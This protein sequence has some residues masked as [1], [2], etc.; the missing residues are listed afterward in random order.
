MREQANLNVGIL[1]IF[2]FEI[3]PK[4]YF[5]QVF[6]NY[7]F[8]EE[9]AEYQKEG[10]DVSK[11]EFVDNIECLNMIEK[12]PVGIF[13]M[14]DEE[15]SV[16]RGNDKALIEKMHK[17]FADQQK[18]KYYKRIRKKPETFTIMHY[19]GA[20]TYQIE[21]TL[22][23]NKDQ[24]HDSLRMLVMKSGVKLIRDIFEEV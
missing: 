24:I 7:T 3:F 19:A 13:A 1:D 18:N 17:V 23:K 22:A 4:N 20:V 5:E 2:G 15:C 10:I 11:I 16:P 9:Q 6:N 12:K 8:K 21:G 14:F